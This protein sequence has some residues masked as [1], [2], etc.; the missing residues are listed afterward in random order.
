LKKW[1]EGYNDRIIEEQEQ[2]EGKE[3]RRVTKNE[4]ASKKFISYA[5]LLIAIMCF[6]FGTLI[7]GVL[8]RLLGE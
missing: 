3:V 4:C 1:R 5:I 6:I 8:E 2:V 7:G